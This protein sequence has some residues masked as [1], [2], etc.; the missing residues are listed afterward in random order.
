MV[1]AEHKVNRFGSRYVYYHCT[2]RN[3][4]QRCPQPSV[5]AKELEKQLTQFIERISIDD[6]THEGLMARLAE[7]SATKSVDIG[8]IQTEIDAR[9]ATLRSQQETLTDLRVRGLIDDADYLSRRRDIELERAATE[10]RRVQAEQADNWFEPAE[11]LISFR[12]RAVSWFR[13]GTEETKRLILVTIGSNYRL[14]DKRLSGE[15]RKPFTLRVEQPLCLYW[16][17]QGDDVRTQF[18]SSD[19]E[20]LQI[21][22]NIKKLKAMVEEV[23][24]AA[25]PRLETVKPGPSTDEAAALG[26]L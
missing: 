15:A 24:C 3:N 5:E 19:P 10:E 13:R 17:R 9:I 18:E 14:T 6:E 23:G 22:A 20:L 12:N 11:L 8:A 25:A 26:A 16:W 7:E 21:I 1:T 2:K 4:Y